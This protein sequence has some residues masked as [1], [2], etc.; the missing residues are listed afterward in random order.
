MKERSTGTREDYIKTIYELTALYGRATTNNIAER[1]GIKPASVT[2][3]IQKLA[4]ENPPLLNYRKHRGV[5]LTP[6]GERE[7]LQITRRHRLL[8]MFLQQILGYSW[9]EVHEEA[10]RLEHV[11]SDKF[12]QCIAQVLGNPRYDPHG[13]PIPNNDLQLPPSSGIRLSELR[14]GQQATVQRVQDKDSALLRYLADIGLK[15]QTQLS[16]LDYSP[17]DENLRLQIIGQGQPIV[18]GNRITSQVFVDLA[19]SPFY[20]A[21]LL[22]GTGG[23][24]CNINSK[25]LSS[26]DISSILQQVSTFPPHVHASF[27][28]RTPFALVF[29]PENNNYFITCGRLA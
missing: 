7:A 19:R 10:E 1:L 12:E 24:S 27:G 5:V 8:E 21:N 9:D 11:I 6:E 25:T 4:S 26:R 18:L 22:P 20:R 23:P 2:S 13:D 15:P 16:I 29:K 17:F 28:E 3:M 14:P